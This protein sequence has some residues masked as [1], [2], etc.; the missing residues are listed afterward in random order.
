M[1]FEAMVLVCLLRDPQTCQTLMDIEGPYKT[2]IECEVRAH[3]IAMELPEWMPEYIAVRYK[4]N[5]KG[6]RT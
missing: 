5:R 4:C 1:M 3:E 2:E 6:K